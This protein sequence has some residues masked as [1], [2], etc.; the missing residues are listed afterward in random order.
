LVGSRFRRDPPGSTK[1]FANWANSMSKKQLNI[2]VYTSH[3]P[4]VIMPTWFCHRKIYD[5]LG[6]FSEAGKGTPEDLIFFYKHLRSDGEVLRHDDELLMYRY[7]SQATTFCIDEQTIW[8]LR[9]QEIQDR[10]LSQWESFS[11]WNAGKQGRKFYRSLRIENQKKVKAFCDVDI[12]KIGT[13]YTYEEAMEKPKPRIPIVHFREVEPP[14]IICMKLG[15]YECITFSSPPLRV[16]LSANSYDM[17][18][19]N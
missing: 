17:L 16:S 13:F 1:R 12:K 5:R 4:T 2:Q 9:L 18:V 14:L 7:H 10:V 19:E 11:I 6:G 15:G 3:G 8:D